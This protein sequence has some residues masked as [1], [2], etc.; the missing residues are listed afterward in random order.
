VTKEASWLFTDVPVYKEGEGKKARWYVE[1]QDDVTVEVKPVSGFKLWVLHRTYLSQV[2]EPPIVEMEL[3]G[4]AAVQRTRDYQD[5]DYRRG[6]AEV[7]LELDAQLTQELLQGVVLPKDDA[8]A[9][10]WIGMGR[11]MP[12]DKT[13]KIDLYLVSLGVEAYEDRTMLV[14]AIDAISQETPVAIERAQDFFRHYLGRN[15]VD[16]A[17]DAGIELADD[18]EG[19]DSVGDASL[20]PD[21]EAVVQAAP[22]GA[23]DDAG[24]AAEPEHEGVPEQPGRKRSKRR[25][26]V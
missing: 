3:E 9:M 6:V 21:G 2:P 1:L 16:A 23:G 5:D 13:L 11:P 12:Q 7:F 17:E 4:V 19:R 20:P 26:T 8:W 18:A 15:E 25:E 22:G 14:R 24:P 10:D